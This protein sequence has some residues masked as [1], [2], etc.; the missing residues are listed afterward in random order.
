MLENEVNASSCPF[1]YMTL[2]ARASHSVLICIYIYL[3]RLHLT[4]SQVTQ[5]ALP[6]SSD[7]V[8]PAAFP[9][10]AVPVRDWATNSTQS[11]PAPPEQGYVGHTQRS[12]QPSQSMFAQ[13]DHCTWLD[14]PG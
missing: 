7:R 14:T 11:V 5:P 10:P 4:F 2:S 13:N 9:H 3:V 1:A 8:P 12:V 6:M